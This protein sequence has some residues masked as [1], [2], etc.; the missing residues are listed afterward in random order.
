ME[1]ARHILP[2]SWKSGRWEKADA[3][4][5]A[6]YDSVDTQAS[7]PSGVTAD[8]AG[9]RDIYTVGLSFFPVENLVIKA[10][11]QVRDD[12]ASGLPE[13]FNVGLGWTF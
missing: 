2:D 9:D 13:L 11:Y 3:V 5:F 7:M 6:R 10:D 12:D 1:A 4:V 8:P